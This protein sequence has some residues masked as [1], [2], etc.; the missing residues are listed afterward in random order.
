MFFAHFRMFALHVCSQLHHQTPAGGSWLV[1]LATR[2]L[3]ETPLDLQ[4]TFTLSFGGG[5]GQLL[6]AKVAKG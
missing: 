2:M 1:A 3:L 5:G 6:A 4:V